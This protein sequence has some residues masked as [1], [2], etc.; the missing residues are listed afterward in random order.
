MTFD[1]PDLLVVAP[2]LALVLALAV[3]VQWRRGL[4]LV[5]AYGGRGP[6]LRLL[7]RDLT[8]FPV[9]RIVA[10]PLAAGLLAL[11]AAGPEPE[12]APPPPPP[13]PVDILLAIDVSH[14][15][16]AADTD[17]P[18][19]ERARAL[20]EALAS[21][22]VA[23]RIS[24]TLFADWPYGLVPVTTDPSVIG[25]FAPWVSPELVGTRDQGTS[26]AEVLAFARATWERRPD[27]GAR[28]IVLLVTDGEAHEG[29]APALDSA[30]AVSDAGFEIWTA[31][32]GTPG[33]APLFLPGSE[34]APLL[35]DGSPVVASA[36]PGF[37][38][39][40]AARGRGEFHDVSTPGGLDGLIDALGRG[41]TPAPTAEEQTDPLAW[42]ILLALVLLAFEALID[43]GVLAR[44]HG[45]D[46]GRGAPERAGGPSRYPAGRAARGEAA[47]PRPGRAA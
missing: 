42:A 7:G 15:M 43:A 13:V 22:S 35:H 26:V 21:E 18:R 1:R 32:V 41:S 25:F 3:A 44:R 39:E 33:G 2:A 6:A 37:L 20:V 12:E 47:R 17:G 45:R 19:I 8:R 10:L 27:E 5:R 4:R 9:A 38:R 36:D 28:R 23:D 31:G 40:L 24:L 14:S 16:T 11:V 29:A 34:E 46:R 30:R